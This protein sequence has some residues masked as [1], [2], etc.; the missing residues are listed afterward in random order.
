MASIKQKVRKLLKPKEMGRLVRE[1]KESSDD[2][3]Q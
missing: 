3:K 2:L 1:P